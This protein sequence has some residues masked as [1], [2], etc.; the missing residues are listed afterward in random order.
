MRTVSR[1]NAMPRLSA[2]ASPAANRAYCPQDVTS[3]DNASADHDAVPWVDRMAS[4][5]AWRERGEGDPVVLLHGLGGT[6]ASWGPQLRGLGGRFRCIAWDMPG[7]GDSV[8]LRPLSFA[9]VADRLA[10]LL[11]SL[12]IERADLVGLSFGG[13]HALHTALAHPERVRRMVLADTSPAFGLDGTRAADWIRARLEPLDAGRSLADIAPQ[14]VDAITAM[15]LHGDVRAEIVGAFGGI[16]AD[17]FR[18]AVHCL[19]TH[20][21]RTRLAEISAP[22]RVIVG[23]LDAETPPAYAQAL[24]DGLAD[25][26]LCVLP[27]V[28]HLSPSEDPDGFNRL[29]VEHLAPDAGRD[30]TGGGTPEAPG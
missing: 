30:T 7:Y 20:D 3:P 13:M 26:D 27:G 6:R 17:A 25:A 23:E 4:G 29:V 15:R 19:V 21:V 24:A 28:G 10:G 2:G 16:S 8:P 1:A 18:A 11:D 9:G 5:V 12:G 14:V 22:T